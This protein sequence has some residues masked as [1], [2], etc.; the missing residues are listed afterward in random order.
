MAAG[1]YTL[2]VTDAHNC[3]AQ[4][5][6]QITQPDALTASIIAV[7]KEQCIEQNNGSINL[8][9]SGGTPPYAFMWSNGATTEDI[10]G[11][12]AGTYSV[13]VTDAHGCEA[14]D[15]ATVEVNPS[16]VCSINDALNPDGLPGITCG[17]PG[18]I[19][20]N[21]ISSS[22]VDAGNTYLWQFIN[23]PPAGWNIT[24]GQGTSQITFTSG[25]CK[26]GGVEIQLTITNRF[27][28]VSVC[29]KIIDGIPFETP[30]DV[31]AGADS[32]LNCT[33]TQITLQGSSSV[34]TDS[35][36][37]AT[38]NWTGPGIVSGGNTLTPIVNAGGTYVLA[39][40][41]FPGD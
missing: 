38:I 35:T 15:S 6:I 31:N 19:A 40:T 9:V 13:L 37:P 5:V 33:V 27:G 8:S 21:T 12:S 30:C 4:K 26:V 11:L 23:S 17:F 16:P 18:G 3:T 28:C 20:N 14:S 7:V 39:I 32:L 36:F 22:N 41:V 25:T 24:A 1:S 34:V 2:V 29:T 10:S